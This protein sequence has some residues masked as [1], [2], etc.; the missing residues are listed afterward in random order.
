MQFFELNI[1]NTTFKLAVADTEEKRIKGLSGIEK[2]GE[3]KGMIFILEEPQE[4]YMVM[5]DMNFGL[6]F[7]FLDKDWRVLG[8]SSLLKDDKDGVVSPK[9]CAIVIEIKRGKLEDL[10]LEIGDTI[11]PNK[12][13]DTHYKGVKK[14]KSGGKF[15]LVGEK[16]Y[17]VIEDDI[18]VEKDK[19][20]ILNSKGEVV[21]N[22]EPGSRIFSR[23]HTNELIKYF[24][25]G[26]KLKMADAMLNFLD[27]QENQKQDYVKK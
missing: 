12:D 17:K 9:G 25:K 5:R 3:S 27:I 23:E 16:V 24:R 11:K 13:L 8:F 4:V 1:K 7:I 26:D 15:E 21:A 19:L 20:Q 18:K 2:L 10:N 14:F 22:L 6:D